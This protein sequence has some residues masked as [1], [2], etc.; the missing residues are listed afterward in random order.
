[1][2]PTIRHS[3]TEAEFA[4]LVRG[5]AVTIQRDGQTVELALADI[6]Y[7]RMTRCIEDAVQNGD[8][9]VGMRM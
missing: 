7:S 3:L 2:N 8:I 9:A 5:E 4:A 1:M 6:G